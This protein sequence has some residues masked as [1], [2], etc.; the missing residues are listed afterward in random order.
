MPGR[1][2]REEILS[3]EKVAKLS[4][5]AEVFYRRL[6]S[7]VDDYGRYESNPAVLRARLYPLQV[8]QVRTEDVAGWLAE[9]S[10]ELVAVYAV[11]GKRYLQ[12]LNFKQQ[13]R[14]KSKYPAPE[15]ESEQTPT[16]ADSREQ[17]MTDDQQAPTV[18]DACALRSRSRT[19]SRS[20]VPDGT[21]APTD[22]F[23]PE[24][25]AAKAGKIKFD[26]AKAEF[27][28]IGDEQR[29]RWTAAFPAVDIEAE[30]LK[31]AVWQ[32][33]NPAKRKKRYEAFFSR[34]FDR[35]QE[36]GG[37][38]RTKKSTSA[39]PPVPDGVKFFAAVEAKTC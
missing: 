13:I 11:G 15:G 17:T 37:N 28:G 35:A 36:R 6:M 12:I 33:A 5:A 20:I 9:V 23:G 31:A 2:V 10:K 14:A 8:D 24:P 30:I 25:P 22:L 34:W 4:F 29:A 32:S 1:Y 39:L 3:S 27:V 16:A 21:V 18:A 7:I 26:F 38:A 19:R